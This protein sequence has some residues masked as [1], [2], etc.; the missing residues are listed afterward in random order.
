MKINI[1]V[2]PKNALLLVI[3]LIL[4]P[5]F[6]MAQ[7]HNHWA[8]SF[9]EESSLLSGAVVGGGAG[10]SAI[11]YNP[12]S[13][14]EITGSKFSLSISLFSFDF[15]NSENALGEG[16]DLAS[17]GF[18]VEPRFIS[19]MINPKKHPR[20]SLEFA[21]LNNLNYH[22]DVTQSVDKNLDILT[23][24]P[25]EERYF[26]YFNFSNNSR[27]DWFGFGGSLKINPRLFLGASMFVS[28]NSLGYLY[29]L[30]IEAFPLDSVFVN[31]DYIP[32]YSANYQEIENVEFR[33]YRLLWKFGLLYKKSRFS[34]GLNITTPSIG[35][36]YSDS[37]K[38]THKSKQSNITMPETG[39]PLPNYVVVDSKEAKDVFVNSKSPFSLAAGFTYHSK[40]ATKVFYSTVEYFGGLDPYPVVQANENIDLAAGS[41][42]KELD[43]NEWLTF[44]GGAKPVLNAAVGYRWHIKEQLMLL[45][46]FR[47]DFNYRKDL[48]YKPY[49]ENKIIKG[50]D[51]DNYH[52][53]GGLSWRI[54]GQDIMTG[55]QYTIGREKN[56]KQIVNLSDPVEFNTTEMAPLQG[57]RQNSMNTFF[58][59]ISFY[60]GATFNFGGGNNN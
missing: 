44:I 38:V 25:G 50:L 22:V 21:Y 14:S 26:A 15:Y 27:D 29:T 60:F 33:D 51:L 34:I 56:Q 43:Y 28:V 42:F 36:I 16:I 1:S 19:L 54:K 59:S 5:I 52:I 55:F 40:N 49:T 41:V 35:G 10:P 57:T 9:N 13:I 45:T 47:T 4:F 12:A 31:D 23:N 3:V 6:A 7:S 53:T 46:G 58:N 20:W 17:S 2:I 32:F 18:S 48:D 39:E 8:R 30:D 37:K 24:L 11:Y